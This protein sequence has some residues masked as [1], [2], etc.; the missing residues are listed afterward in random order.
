MWSI[1]GHF[2]VM[3]L[4]RGSSSNGKKLSYILFRLSKLN[5]FYTHNLQTFKIKIY[6]NDKTL[7][8]VDYT[9]FAE[10]SKMINSYDSRP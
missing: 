5:P 8:P 7:M 3:V 1:K 6:R 10:L 2:K 4:K 9:T